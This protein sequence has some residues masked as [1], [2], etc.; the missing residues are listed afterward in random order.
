M[1]KTRVVDT[2]SEIAQLQSDVGF[3]RQTTFELV[4]I[5][6]QHPDFRGHISELVEKWPHTSCRNISLGRQE[7][8]TTVK[9]D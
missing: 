9:E 6:G 4:S 5:L 8:H 3:L 2:Q 1:D 7:V